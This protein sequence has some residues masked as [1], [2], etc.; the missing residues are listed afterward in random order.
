MR[1]P[2]FAF[3]VVLLLVVGLSPLGGQQ[4][5]HGQTPPSGLSSG[6]K[7]PPEATEEKSEVTPPKDVAYWVS[8]LGDEHFLRRQKASQELKEMGPVIIPE[9]VAAMENGDLEVIERSIGMISE[10][11]L[12]RMP[13]ED[14]GAWYT[15]QTMAA[16]SVGRRGLAAR[17]AMEEVRDSRFQQATRALT[18]AGVLLRERNF[19]VSALRESLEV[20]EI[21]NEWNGDVKALQWLEWI[22]NTR[23]VHVNGKALRGDVISNVVK[24]PKLL[25]IAMT[26]GE[27]GVSDEVFSALELMERIESLDVRYVA[28][29]ERQGEIISR[30]PIRKSLNLMGTGIKKDA[31]EN[32]KRKLAGLDI[33]YR[34]GGFLGVSCYPDTQICSINRVHENT[35]AF[36]AGLLFGDVIVGVGES[37]VGSFTDLQAAVN[38][39]RAG[40]EVEIRYRRGGKLLKVNVR[41][42]RLEEN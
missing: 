6:D 39:H 18:A 12:T 1:L 42:K 40:D 4:S 22:D 28:L 24:M 33:Q 37:P 9:L 21:G 10:F 36:E 34:Q 7:L 38:L 35:A 11:A 41:L 25:A 17:S 2:L 8:Q 3:T 32:I 13:S 31:V 30:L 27:A 23:N 20:A 15:L 14:G 29:T 5:S 26:D 16:N 19:T